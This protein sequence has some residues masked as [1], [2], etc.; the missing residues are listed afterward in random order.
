MKRAGAKERHPI[1]RAITFRLSALLEFSFIVFIS[2]ARRL[3]MLSIERL[4]ISK[5]P[6]QKLRPGWYR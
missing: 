6:A 5:A 1:I 4:T 2:D 3:S